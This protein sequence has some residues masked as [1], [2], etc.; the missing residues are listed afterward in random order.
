M[1][2]TVYKINDNIVS[3][4]LPDSPFY[5]WYDRKV[6]QLFADKVVTEEA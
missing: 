6:R 1:G 2:Y 4:L 3:Q 5:W